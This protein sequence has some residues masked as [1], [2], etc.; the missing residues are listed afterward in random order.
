[1]AAYLLKATLSASDVAKNAPAVRASLLPGG[2][3]EVVAS[4]GVSADSVTE[5]L[6]LAGFVSVSTDSNGTISAK[7]PSFAKSV[8]LKRRKKKE[9]SA[10]SAKKVWQLVAED[11]DGDYDVEDE[12][13]LL[14]ETEG[15]LAEAA[16][17]RE[18]CATA[19]KAGRRRACKDCTCGL[20][21][22]EG[23]EVPPKDDE[24]A[25]PPESACGNCSKGDAFRCATCPY[26]GTP[27]FDADAPKPKIITTADGGVKLEL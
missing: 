3:V 8:P 22:M 26:L 24:E 18:D 5:A 1:M 19:V 2:E 20:R 12:D 25:A 7:T 14:D 23:N 21:D 11:D 15:V 6:V 16:K 4:A 10:E 13:A 9:K 27:A 17:E